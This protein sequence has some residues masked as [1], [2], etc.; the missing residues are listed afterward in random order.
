MSGNYQKLNWQEKINEYTIDCLLDIAIHPADSKIILLIIP[1]VDGSVDGYE[2]KYITI[3]DDI[4]KKFDAAVVRISN[5][6]VSS[7]LWES[8]I[9]K[10]LQFIEDNAKTITNNDNIEL[11]IMAH[12]AGA[13]VIAQIAWEYPFIS[14]LLLINPAMKLGSDKIKNGLSKFGYD[15][16]TILVGGKD[17]SLS[18]TTELKVEN[19]VIVDGA[20][21]NFSGDAF[22]VFL[23]SP[24]K[25]LFED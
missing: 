19:T 10:A 3:A 8:N 24:S 1:G 22:P 11:R 25:Y 17:P 21:H 14:K 23:D 7:Y 20:D 5:P 9:R 15:K 4:Q 16:V 12:S 2:N 13:G 18:E 6:F